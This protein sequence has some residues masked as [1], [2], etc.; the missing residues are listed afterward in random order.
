M[1]PAAGLPEPFGETRTALSFAG[2]LWAEARTGIICSVK[3]LVLD[4]I[5]TPLPT[6]S[7]FVPGRNQEALEASRGAVF[8]TP[9]CKV[10]YLWGPSGSGKSHLARA[11]GTAPQARLLEPDELDGLD[12]FEAGI[13]CHALDDVQK[14]DDRQ[15]IALF[16]LINLVNQPGN[17][18]RVLATGSVAP[19]DL[20]L[21]PELN[22]RLGSGLVFQL[23]P[24]SDAE[25][26]EAL[27]SHAKARSFTL[28]DEV[29]AYLLRHARRDMAS[30]ISILD[31]LDRHSLE[32][33]RE[34]TLPMLREMA[35]PTLL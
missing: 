15:Q 8:G 24:L 2:P 12:N 31:A 26:A 17:A 32:T 30:L 20:P 14:L 5:P 22:S 6:F 10:L 28:R 35:Q 9:A 34:I 11:L 25:K 19:R 4:L 33:G 18:G 29:I 1:L 13:N 7:N 21:R 27:R 3:Q 23:H 16:N